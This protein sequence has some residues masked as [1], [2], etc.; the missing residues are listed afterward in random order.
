MKIRNG[1][2]TKSSYV[3]QKMSMITRVMRECD[4]SSVKKEMFNDTVRILFA[5]AGLE[6]LNNNG[7]T[8]RGLRDQGYFVYTDPRKKDYVTPGRSLPDMT[9]TAEEVKAVWDCM[10]STNEGELPPLKI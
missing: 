4:V 5:E 2:V 1:K 10:T 8:I 3:M 7:S 9:M 6:K